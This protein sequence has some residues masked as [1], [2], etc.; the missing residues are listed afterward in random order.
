LCNHP[1]PRSPP[2][3]CA[4]APRGLG[5]RSAAAHA[6]AAYFASWADS[7]RAIRTRESIFCE[8]ILQQLAGPPLRIAARCR[9]RPDQPRSERARLGR[10]QPPAGAEADPALH[11]PP[12]L[13][14]GWQ[15]AASKVV[16]DALLADVTPALDEAST[17]L[18]SPRGK[19]NLLRAVPEKNS[20]LC[21]TA[22]TDFPCCFDPPVPPGRPCG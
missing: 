12:D 2:G 19:T 18:P 8:D 17:A 7:L 6:P 11:E 14:R 5:L 15:R 1:Q 16:D 9:R 4:A 22:L 3:S 13:A 20:L 21:R 10:A